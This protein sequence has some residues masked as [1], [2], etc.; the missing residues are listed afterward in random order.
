MASGVLANAAGLLLFPL[1]PERAPMPEH[2]NNELNALIDWI[3]KELAEGRSQNHIAAKM[4]AQGVEVGRAR[5]IVSQ[6]ADSLQR[7]VTPSIGQRF[8]GHALGWGAGILIFVLIN[9]ALYVGQEIYH[10]GDV[11]RAEALEAQLE[12]LEAGIERLDSFL[13]EKANESERLDA[14]GQKLD[15]PEANYLTEAAYE[16]DLRRYNSGVKRWNANLEML[17]EVAEQ[18]ESKVDAYNALVD[19]YNIVAEAAYSRW[20]LIPIPGGGRSRSHLGTP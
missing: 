19:K 4:A 7:G 15:N 5:E 1:S 16:S 14:L 20:Y 17:Q 10:R 2:R 3:A 18:R 11:Q 12:E 13:A 9:G 6:V 8:K